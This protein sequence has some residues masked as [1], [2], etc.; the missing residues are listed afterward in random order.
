[1]VRTKA[2]RE[3]AQAQLQMG[4]TGAGHA[5]DCVFCL[6]CGSKC[7]VELEQCPLFRYGIDFAK[8]CARALREDTQTV[9]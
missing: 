8:E 3:D 2:A 6:G 1:M 4:H 5:R 7:S 9:G